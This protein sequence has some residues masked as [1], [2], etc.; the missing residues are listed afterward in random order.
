MRLMT[1]LAGPALLSAAAVDAGGAAVQADILPETLEAALEALA[2]A[3]AERDDALSAG[4][5]AIT[6]LGESLAAAKA[7]ATTAEKALQKA[8]RALEQAKGK[9]SVE[10]A[11][12][13]L[14]ADEGPTF[15]VTVLKGSVRHGGGK[16]TAGDSFDAFETDRES[17]LDLRTRGVVGFAD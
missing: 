9:T 10:S 5:Q 2:A 11:P 8:E 17:L 15:A 13:P 1:T 3:R 7:R 6:D 14:A 12:E 16:T 4:A